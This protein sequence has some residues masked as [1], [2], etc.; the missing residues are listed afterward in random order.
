[1][2]DR[3][4]DILNTE[5][6]RYGLVLNHFQENVNNLNNNISHLIHSYIIKIL[7]ETVPLKLHRQFT[8]Q[9]KNKLI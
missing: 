1:M 7:V 5:S 3:P 8:H 2:V 4:I 6:G 9:N